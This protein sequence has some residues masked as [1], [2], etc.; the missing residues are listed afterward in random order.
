MLRSVKKCKDYAL[1][2]KDGRIGHAK[3]F[4]FDDSHWT[5]RYLVAQAGNW[6]TGQLVLLSP[7]ALGK[8][9]DAEK[10]IPV[11]LTREQIENSPAPETERPLSRQFEADY[12]RYFGWPYY[13]VGPYLWGPSPYPG[14]SLD[15]G[16]LTG[17][18]T[19]R[20]IRYKGDPHLRSTDEVSGYHIAAHDGEIGH[21]EDYLFDDSDWSIHYVTVN[22][23][24]WWPGKRVLIPPSW[25]GDIKWEERL[26]M[27]DA[28]REDILNAPAYNRDQPVSEELE[29]RLKEYFAVELRK[30]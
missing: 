17:P 22:T 18:R 7:H 5:L 9:D 11:N 8:I 4:Y 13:W 23:H 25:I 1:G 15:P 26:V 14:P 19:G 20:D 12:F 2:A 21:V 3:E 28:D 10:T 27:V 29:R 30:A 16:G 24:N 6:L